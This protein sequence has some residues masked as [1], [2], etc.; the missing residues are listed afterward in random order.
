M[1]SL[2]SCTTIHKYPKTHATVLLRA[3]LRF[4]EAPYDPLEELSYTSPRS[5]L[6]KIHTWVTPCR[7]ALPFFRTN[8]LEVDLKVSPKWDRGSKRVEN[9]HL[10][11]LLEPNSR[12]GDDLTPIP[13]SLSPKRECGSKGVKNPHLNNLLEPNSGFGDDLT[14]IPSNLSPKKGVRF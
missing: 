5:R 3:H 12:F 2:G 11:S 10:I 6:F 1:S 14:P 13:S 8:C 4:S 7:T 9:S